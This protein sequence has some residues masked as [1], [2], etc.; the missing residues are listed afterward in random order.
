MG[1]ATTYL[2][3]VA[4]LAALAGWTAAGVAVLVAR[5][6]RSRHYGLSLI[7]DELEE[8]YH[9]RAD[10]LHQ[11]S[12]AAEVGEI[13]TLPPNLAVELGVEIDR[14][15]C[16][17]CLQGGRPP[18]FEPTGECD[19]CGDGSGLRRPVTVRPVLYAGT[20]GYGKDMGLRRFIAEHVTDATEVC[21]IDP[22]AGERER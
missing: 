19:L 14:Y 12:E 16:P 5:H 4:A 21:V 1:V 22:K 18:A 13:P 17:E 6:W 11:I 8:Q 2:L 9:E 3:T 15:R 10:L 20:P 7:T